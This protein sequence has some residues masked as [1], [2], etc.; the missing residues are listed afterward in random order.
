MKFR[1]IILLFFQVQLAQ[2][3]VSSQ[4]NFLPNFPSEGD[5]ITISVAAGCP[6]NV[7]AQNQQGQT[8]VVEQ[9]SP[10]SIIV[11]VIYAADIGCVG[12]PPPSP[13]ISFELGTLVEGEYTIDIFFASSNDS[14]PP[15][16]AEL[17][18]SSSFQ[19]GAPVQPVD[20]FTDTTKT[21]LIA[22]FLMLGL[23]TFKST[24]LRD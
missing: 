21:L 14:T 11:T 1:L 16:L 9:V 4:I 17:L 12:V 7:P 8:F 22:L 20:M 23:L 13:P 15:L 6:Y 19:V 24:V 10:N 5:L 18:Y 3:G 2:S